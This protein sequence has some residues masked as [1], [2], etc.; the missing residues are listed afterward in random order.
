VPATPARYK[1]RGTGRGVRSLNF[2]PEM[3]TARPLCAWPSTTGRRSTCIRHTINEKR[4]EREEVAFLPEKR[5]SSTSRAARFPI[6]T[7][8]LCRISQ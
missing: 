1:R 7:P 8:I 3:A 5:P 6:L 4:N 2:D